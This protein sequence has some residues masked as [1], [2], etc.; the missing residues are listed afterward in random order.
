MANGISDGSAPGA[1]VTRQQLAAMLYRYAV[2][3]GMA[4]VTLEE[5]LSGYPDGAAVSS[6][7]VQAM[8][9]AV[10]RGIISGMSDGTLNPGGLSNRAQ[11]A[12]IL[13]RFHQFF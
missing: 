8:N 4:A 7:A 3:R 13:Y 6:Y 1:P 9:W 5:H 2:A 12:V 10:G 11:L